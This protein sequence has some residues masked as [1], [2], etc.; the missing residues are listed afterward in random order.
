MSALATFLL[1][2]LLLFGICSFLA[3]RAAEAA[4]GG[5]KLY[6]AILVALTW[7]T[8]I[9]LGGALWWFIGFGESGS[10]AIPLPQQ[11]RIVHSGYYFSRDGELRL[12]GKPTPETTPTP[13]QAGDEE[14]RAPTPELK[15]IRQL[16]APSRGAQAAANAGRPGDAGELSDQGFVHPALDPG[17]SITLRPL[18]EGDRAV[19]WVI[20]FKVNSQPLRFETVEGDRTV[21]RC[22]NLSEERWLNPKDTLLFTLERGGKTEF[23]TLRWEVGSKFWWRFKKLTNSY[24]YG[25]GTVSG[26]RLVY[27]KGPDVLLSEAVLEE[28]FGLADLVK[29]GK[30]EFGRESGTIDEDWWSIFNGITLVREVRSDRGSRLGVLV[31]DELFDQ[32]NLKVYKNYTG[33]QT[34]P[35]SALSGEV[36]AEVGSSTGIA[37][38]LGHRNAFGLAL[39]EEVVEDGIWGQIVT[40]DL[41]HPQGWALPPSPTKDFIITTANDYIPLD[42][43]FIDV[44]ESAHSF[45]AKARL[46][47]GLNVLNINDGKN[48]ESESGEQGGAGT[49]D[50]ARKFSLGQHAT[51]GDYQQGILLRLLQTRAAL[52]YV[53]LLAIS[54]LALNALIFTLVIFRQRSDRPKLYL[55]WT[56]I[57]CSTL[58]L[59]TVRLLLAYRASLLPPLDAS[60]K[61]IQNVFH[62]GVLISLWG[63]AACGALAF[64]VPA[65]AAVWSWLNELRWIKAMRDSEPFNLVLTACWGGAIALW[66]LLGNNL[67]SNQAFLGF[68]INMIVHLLVIFGISLL[69]RAATEGGWWQRLLLCAVVVIA[70]SL[71]VLVIG[72]AGAIIYLISLASCLWP[73]LFWHQISVWPRSWA[74]RAATFLTASSPLLLILSIVL[75]PIFVLPFVTQSQ[76]IRGTVRPALPTTTFYRF[77][78]FTDS[79]EALLTAKSGD[80]EAAVN[81]LLDNSR[82]DWQMLLYASHGAAQRKEYGQTP[83]SRRGMTYSTSMADCVF[84]IYLLSEHGTVAAGLVLMLYLTLGCVCIVAGWSLPADV[85]HRNL[86]LLAIGGFV[87]CN[88][89]YMAG[90]NVGLTVFTG[91]NVP[92]LGL[93]SGTDLLQCLMLVALAGCL[94]LAAETDATAGSM[95]AAHPLPYWTAAAFCLGMTLWLGVIIWQITRIGGEEKYRDDHNFSRDFF[96][97]VK[98]N[99]PPGD[100]AR[101]G[102]GQNRPWVLQGDRL[103]RKPGGKVE[104][105]EEQYARQ[106]NER[107]DKFNP[108]GGFYYLEKT[109]GTLGEQS[110][111]V[112]VNDRYF[113]AMS[114]FNESKMWSGRIVVS[115]RDDPTIYALGG[116]LTVSLEES[117]YPGSIDLTRTLPARATSSVLVTESGIQFCEL[118][119]VDG[120]LRLDPKSRLNQWSIYVDGKKITS[121]I[122]LQPLSIVVIERKDSRFRRN[123]IYL[124][125]TP[126]VVAFV[127][128]RNGTQRRI[129]TG[130]AFPFAYLL[131]K[132]GDMAVRMEEN[133]PA[134]E[135]RLGEQLS[136]TIDP[137]LQ[138]DLQ[139]ELGLYAA[140]DPNYSPYQIQPNRLAVTLM[141][142]FSGRVLAL[143]SWPRFNPGHAEY[144]GLVGKIPESTRTRFESNHNLTNHAVGSTFK[145]ITFTAM[146]TSL[147]A[148]NIDLEKMVIFNRPDRYEA[149]ANGESPLH[150]HLSVG[151]IKIGMWDCNSPTPRIDMRDFLVHSRDFPQGVIGMMGMVADSREV[152][153][154]LVPGTP[155]DISYEGRDYKFDLT[156]VSETGTA[157]SLND[158]FEGGNPSTRGPEAVKNTILFR[159]LSDLFDFYYPDGSWLGRT[160]STFLPSFSNQG[161]SLQRNFYLDDIIP[162]QIDLANGDFQDIRGGLI[163]CLL[164]GGDCGFNNVKMAEA[165]TRLST[166]RRVSARLEDIAPEEPPPMPAPLGVAQWRNSNIITPMQQVGEVGTAKELNG[167]VKLPPMFRAIYKTGTLVEGSG[168][169]ESE[170]LIFVIGRWEN[171]GFVKGESV[172]G[173]LYMEKSKIKDK[174]L[175]D[176]GMKKFRFAKP[177]LERVVKY[178]IERRRAAMNAVPTRENVTG[179]DAG[180]KPSSL[181]SPL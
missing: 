11:R 23:V 24:Y 65:A 137:E 50:A 73:L 47:E 168:N 132:A 171:Q 164:G 8:C 103:E 69:A 131:G 148:A 74:S 121:A 44:G 145:P 79:E 108:D 61:E 64:A 114:P 49:A 84:A 90:A 159:M 165:A 26:G 179:Q 56:L 52:P 46:D 33:E 34:R 106:F 149:G 76:W 72:D 42:G 110:L 176:G 125:A 91:Q 68:R 156:K 167:I 78:S 43:Y 81:V 87:A 102:T 16:I 163:S 142:A 77:A 133:L 140:S 160:S 36:M 101:A 93:Y 19:K 155:P 138:E 174:S 83:L 51:L 66:I 115:G 147:R 5:Y 6:K 158:Q 40:V 17:E 48:L 89:L 178:L 105:I 3:L 35:F 80:E 123:L 7:L 62:K 20:N 25:R 75:L 135:R 14:A 143:G 70:L 41:K 54:L 157:F 10:N 98:N 173:F 88:A 104:E 100:D 22:V 92:L 116:S 1:P 58:A 31:A 71:Q 95:R 112:K 38:G 94:L 124:G 130:D 166:G 169:R 134:S 120:Q 161:L 152:S 153:K 18:W 154:A 122:D 172:A 96:A 117:G 63:L 151:K 109:R 127:R 146:A 57:W 162:A 86:P 53:G 136:L 118:K 37:Y 119:R 175:T 60:P 28:G 2:I 45:Y 181:R 82:Q 27:T 67:G 29:R 180:S 139:K 30:P 107:A 111:R 170:A 85:R 39:S 55:A 126:P 13:E 12:T 141:D 129:F 4:G 21:S 177:V 97:R 32:P 150:P 59:L 144:E 9:S 113:F 15:V 99:L 128:W